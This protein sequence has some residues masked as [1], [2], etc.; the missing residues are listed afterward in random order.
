MSSEPFIIL[1]EEK[2]SQGSEGVREWF[3]WESYFSSVRGE[4]NGQLRGR[5]AQVQAERAV[6]PELWHASLER[7]PR[8]RHRSRWR[9][10]HRILQP[11]H[12]KEGLRNRKSLHSR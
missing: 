5:N 3:S 4:Q 10:I 2:G 9:K 8:R 1:A 11:L 7:R 6:L 12:V